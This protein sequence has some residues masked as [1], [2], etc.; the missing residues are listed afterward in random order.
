MFRRAITRSIRT[1]CPGLA[2]VKLPE[3]R[4]P[5]GIRAAPHEW[6][7]ED[8]VPLHTLRADIDLRLGDEA[9]TACGI[10]VWVYK[11]RS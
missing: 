8:R 7:H 3:R 2:L 9:P 10:K 4:A 1:P 5:H 11:A 6:D